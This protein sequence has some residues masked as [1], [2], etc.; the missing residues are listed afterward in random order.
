MCALPRLL[1][2]HRTTTPSS[3]TTCRTAGRSCP[4]PAAVGPVNGRGR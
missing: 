4:Y 3:G 2:R 1:H